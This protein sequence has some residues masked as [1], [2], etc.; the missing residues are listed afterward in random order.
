MDVQTDPIVPVELSVTTETVHSSNSS[1]TVQTVSENDVLNIGQEIGIKLVDSD[2]RM[3]R[4]ESNYVLAN[5]EAKSET[6]SV[7][8][9]D[10]VCPG[11]VSTMTG[12][13]WVNSPVDSMYPSFKMK[14]FSIGGN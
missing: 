9:F 4:S 5:C 2:I 14:I 6:Q 1:V 12:F 11:P 13:S 3:K 10:G 8:L 7:S